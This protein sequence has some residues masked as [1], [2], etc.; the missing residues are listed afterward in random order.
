M[1]HN[2]NT[3][4]QETAAPPQGMHVHLTTWLSGQYTLKWRLLNAVSRLVRVVWA[5]I[6]SSS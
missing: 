3:L 2:G 5:L 4:D 1:K 6:K